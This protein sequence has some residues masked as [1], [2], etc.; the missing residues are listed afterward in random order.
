MDPLP[1]WNLAHPVWHQIITTGESV[2]LVSGDEW[3]HKSR[4]ER[5]QEALHDRFF[6]HA[7]NG[8]VRAGHAHVRDIGCAA[9]Q[10]AIIGGGD[11]RVRA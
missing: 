7:D 1:D 8:I 10:H 2:G 5:I 6:L 3:H 4:W 9:G 11:V